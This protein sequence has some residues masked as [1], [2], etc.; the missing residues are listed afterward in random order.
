M[1]SG[2]LLPDRVCSGIPAVANY[3]GVFGTSDIDDCMA[4]PNS[5]CL[6]EGAMFQ[7]SAVS[8]R[9]FSDGLSNSIVVGEHKTRR[10]SG[11]NWTSTWAGVVANGED[12]IVRL[13]GTCDH[14]PNHPANHIDDFSSHHSGGA[15]F[16]LGDGSV[17]F[18]GTSIDLNVYQH[19][20]T[21]AAG[22]IVGEF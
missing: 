9:G 3:V 7:N 14:T 20:V 8:F 16:L 17:R 5:P 22:D 11:F 10:D 18:I 21:R 15:F 4:L 19:L 13:L 1:P 2:H 6:G 12:A